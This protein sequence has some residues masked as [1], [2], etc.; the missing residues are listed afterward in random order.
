M[1]LL[2]KISKDHHIIKKID[3][4]QKQKE[5]RTNK[6]HYDYHHKPMMEQIF[7]QEHINTMV[8]YM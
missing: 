3:L 6:I 5:L 4:V 2:S 1:K 7:M 8:V